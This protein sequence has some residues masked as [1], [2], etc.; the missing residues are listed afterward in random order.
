MHNVYGGD[1]ILKDDSKNKFLFY[2]GNLTFDSLK[3]FQYY[4]KKMIV[5]IRVLYN[6]AKTQ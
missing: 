1:T 6:R 2:I 4:V 3:H 5:K